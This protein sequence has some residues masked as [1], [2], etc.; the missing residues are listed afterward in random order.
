MV[1]SDDLRGHNPPPDSPSGL[2]PPRKRQRREV[3]DDEEEEDLLSHL[4]SAA[5]NER[6]IPA[7]VPILPSSSSSSEPPHATLE[8]SLLE[9]LTCSTCAQ[10]LYEPL[11]TPCQH[12]FCTRCALRYRLMLRRCH[13]QKDPV[14]GLILTPRDGDGGEFGT[15]AH[16]VHVEP[17]SNNLTT[18]RFYGQRRF[19][20]MERAKLDGYDVARLA[21]IDDYADDLAA[22]HLIDSDEEGEEDPTNDHEDKEGEQSDQKRDVNSEEASSASAQPSGSS[23]NTDFRHEHTSSSANQGSSSE[24]SSAVV[25]IP[26]VPPR[27]HPSQ[28]GNEELMQYCRDFIDHLRAGRTPWVSPNYAQL[29]EM[30]TDVALFTFWVGHSL[31]LPPEQIAK[32]LPI[33]SPRMRLLLISHWIKELNQ[34]W[35]W[36]QGCVV[37]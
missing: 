13:E 8:S 11:T 25:R 1:N 16:I 28:P 23:S 37:C 6:L 27:V 4:R 17:L 7:D 10:L 14:F 20:I 32:L 30:P 21:M 9:E 15:L 36:R 18:V 3:E 34:Q 26:K 31:P 19:R 12:T 2:E 35:W 29:P 22:T 24:S 33:R 5:A